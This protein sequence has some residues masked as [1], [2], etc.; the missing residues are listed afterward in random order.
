MVPSPGVMV[1]GNDRMVP[2]PGATVPGND[3]M[4]PSPGA[5]VPGNDRM[6]PLPGVMVP[7]NDRV[8]PLPGVMVPGND[9]M[10]PS[11]RY[12]VPFGPS[13]VFQS[14]RGRFTAKNINIDRLRQNNPMSN[15]WQVLEQFYQTYR[16]LFDFINKNAVALVLPLIGLGWWWRRQQRQRR[17][18][19]DTFPFDVVPPQ[20]ESEVVKV[21]YGKNEV[22]RLPDWE[23]PYQRRSS[24]ENTLDRLEAALAETGWLLIVG[25]SG[26]GKTREAAELARLLNQ[27]GWT[28]VNLQSSGW[29]DVRS[30]YPENLPRRRLLFLLDDLNQRMQIGLQEQAPKAKEVISSP[31]TVPLQERLLNLLKYFE[32]ALSPAEVRVIATARNEGVPD[33]GERF[34][35][36]EKLRWEKYPQFWQRFRVY[37][38]KKPEDE[39]VADLFTDTVPRTNLTPQPDLYDDLARCNDGTFRNVVENLRRLENRKLPLSLQN[40]RPTLK[41]NWEDNYRIAVGKFPATPWIFDAIRLLQ[42]FGVPLYPF[43][44]IPTARMLL[45]QTLRQKSRRDFWKAISTYPRYWLNIPQALA[46]LEANQGIL[47]PRDGQIAAKPDPLEPAAYHVQYLIDLLLRLVDQH[48]QKLQASLLNI[49]FMLVG[50]GNIRDALN[51]L[52]K[53]LKFET[54]SSLLWF[55]HGTA[56]GK[57]GAY[58]EAIASYDQA[59]KLKPNDDVAWNERGNALEHLGRYEEALI[60]YNQALKFKPEDS[61][62]LS[63]RGIVQAKLGQYED[64]IASFDQSLKIK[65]D[66]PEN[67]Y[68]RGIVLGNLGRYK[69]AIASYDK[70]IEINPEYSDAWI[71]RSASLGDLKLF[72][73][74][75][76]SCDQA[77]KYKPDSHLALFN[78]A[79]FHAIQ[80]EV[81][82]TLKNLQKAV[83][84]SAEVRQLAK[85]DSYF[86]SIRQDP[87]FQALINPEP[88]PPSE[89]FPGQERF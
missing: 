50:Q 42:D 82:L 54:N 78:K 59:L 20:S 11:P 77:L 31:L 70:A 46:Y 24:S 68:S 2:S 88:I 52:N 67:W 47:E 12:T 6:V 45:W 89:E 58:K 75:I 49:A 17:I 74:A 65:P 1:P 72:N 73:Q 76:A 21:V 33:Q 40:F 15:L 79:C 66:D 28:V 32:D 26:L 13:V 10:V 9:R 36:W 63:N 69:E 5:T 25:K 87:R 29:V 8:V 35:A 3:R 56:L 80:G 84:I 81:E 44:V 30:K 14:V 41:G 85:I 61:D 57:S 16:D 27:E 22:Q 43:T 86:D 23:V 38:L 4:V 53:L 39:A 34:S 62:T 48:P 60:S 71:N 19:T 55:G 18:A 37:E 51:C 83:A 64:A 7:G